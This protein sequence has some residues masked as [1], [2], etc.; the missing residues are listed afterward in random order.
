MWWAELALI[1]VQAGLK[2]GCA[3]VDAYPVTRW[4]AA[5]E[6]LTL[7]A[8]GRRGAARRRGLLPDTDPQRTPAFY[9]SPSQERASLAPD[10]SASMLLQCCQLWARLLVF[11]VGNRYLGSLQ[12]RRIFLPCYPYSY[13]PWLVVGTRLTFIHAVTSINARLLIKPNGELCS[14]KKPLGA[15]NRR[16]LPKYMSSPSKG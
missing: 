14:N 8:E 15:L 1:G 3:A 5:N 4:F 7:L 2:G 10:D 11:I 6:A 9:Q 12:V 13:K 16:L